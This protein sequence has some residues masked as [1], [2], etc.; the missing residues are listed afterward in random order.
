MEFQVKQ[1]RIEPGDILIGYTDG[2]TE[3]MS[4]QQNLFGK[5]RFLTLL[6]Q[7][8]LTAPKLIDQIK[9]E[10]FNHID[11]APQ[12]DDITMIAVRREKKNRF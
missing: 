7:P 9:L 6:E 12:F 1:V 11:N 2:V 8:A 5:K 10:L 4:P 3:A